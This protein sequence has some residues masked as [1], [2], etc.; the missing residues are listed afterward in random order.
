MINWLE[1]C[2]VMGMEKKLRHESEDGTK[3]KRKLFPHWKNSV[4]SRSQFWETPEIEKVEWDEIVPV[5]PLSRKKQNLK[6]DTF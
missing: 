1:A 6:K 5:V 4:K 3:K 2:S